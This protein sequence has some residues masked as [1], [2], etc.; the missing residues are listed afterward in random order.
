MLANKRLTEAEVTTYR[1]EGFLVPKFRLENEVL[2]KLQCA[3]KQLVSDFPDVQGGIRRPHLPRNNHSPG[4]NDHRTWLDIATTPAL[5]DALEQLM[6]SDFILWTSTL[7]NKWPLDAGTPWHR[8]GN[9]Y[10]LK[11]LATTTVWIA[12]F[13]VKVESACLRFIPRS[14][15]SPREELSQ[16]NIELD[17]RLYLSNEQESTAVD[18]ELRAGEMV[19]FD[20]STV[21]GSWPNLSEEP[22]AGYAIRYF[23]ATSCFDRGANPVG[24]NRSL[25]LV[26]GTDRASNGVTKL[27]EARILL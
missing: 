15:L 1:N 3:T 5:L 27:E 25:I 20:V 23:P 6:G 11:P 13:D 19:F 9:R 16:D 12:A 8:D 7:F 2:E 18:V 21:H 14:N 26:R 4:N 17:G 22:R 24:Q 10:P